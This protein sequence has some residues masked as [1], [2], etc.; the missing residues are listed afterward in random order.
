MRR[1]PA[2]KRGR[3]SQRALMDEISALGSDMLRVQPFS[4]QGVPVRLPEESVDMVRRIQLPRSGVPT[5]SAM[6]TSPAPDSA[7]SRPDATC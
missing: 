3:S 2:H 5:S 7:C 4:G 6:R 1:P